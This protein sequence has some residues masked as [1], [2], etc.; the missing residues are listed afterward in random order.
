MNWTDNPSRSIQR[1]LNTSKQWQNYDVFK[2]QKDSTFIKS[3][4]AVEELACR[5]MQI[6]ADTRLAQKENKEEAKKVGKPRRRRKNSIVV[7]AVHRYNLRP[8]P[9]RK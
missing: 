9:A 6:V 8:R 7:P 3:R 1:I 4:A 2:R 5:Y